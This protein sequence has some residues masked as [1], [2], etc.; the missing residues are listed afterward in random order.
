MKNLSYALIYANKKLIYNIICEITK[1]K[2]Y[3]KTQAIFS[4]FK[5]NNEN[6]I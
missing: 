6:K 2:L 3:E 1:E 4:L 5:E